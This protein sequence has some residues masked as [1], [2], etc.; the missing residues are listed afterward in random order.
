MIEVV[1]SRVTGEKKEK[2]WKKELE[3]NRNRSDSPDKMGRQDGWGG[4]LE[5]EKKD[6]F[7]SRGLRMNEGGGKGRSSTRNRQ[8]PASARC[9]R[10]GSNRRQKANRDGPFVGVRCVFPFSK[11]KER[12]V[13]ECAEKICV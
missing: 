7:Q 4:G 2:S 12:L 8:T 13:E 1:G 6:I 9:C 3:P 11:R 5:R 10:G